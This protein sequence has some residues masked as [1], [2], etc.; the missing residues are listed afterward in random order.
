[1]LEFLEESQKYVKDQYKKDISNS[2]YFQ[3]HLMLIQ[4][5][6]MLESYWEFT[7]PEYVIEV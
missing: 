1:M 4:F 7:E 3:A 6:G 5:D 2:F